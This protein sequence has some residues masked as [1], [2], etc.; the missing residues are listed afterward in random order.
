MQ[1]W[2]ESRECERLL[3]SILLAA[4]FFLD[5]SHLTRDV[6]S[7]HVPAEVSSSIIDFLPPHRSFPYAFSAE[8]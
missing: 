8:A 3:L 5:I 6:S 1:Q 4:A 7:R 2:D